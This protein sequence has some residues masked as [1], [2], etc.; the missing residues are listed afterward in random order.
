MPENPPFPFSPFSSPFSFLS[1]NSPPPP[2]PP[3]FFFGFLSF[4]LFFSFPISHL[5]LPSFLLLIPFFSISFLFGSILTELVKG[6]SFLPL[7]SCQLCGPCFSSIFP[8]FFI[9]IYCIIFHVANCEPHMALSMCHSLGV[10][11]GIPLTTPCV[12]RHPTPRKT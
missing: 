12:I 4:L 8:Y 3:P 2:P 9:F 5:I 7:S 1:T 11:C 6:G 10:P